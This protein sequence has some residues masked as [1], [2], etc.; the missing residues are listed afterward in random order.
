[1]FYLLLFVIIINIVVVVVVVVVEHLRMDTL[2]G[3]QCSLK[4]FPSLAF[5]PPSRSGRRGQPHMDFGQ[6]VVTA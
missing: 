1:M 3:T 5:G 4:T 2:T 6:T